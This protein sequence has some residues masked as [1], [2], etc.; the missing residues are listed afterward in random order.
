MASV[1]VPMG[2]GGGRGLAS[3]VTSRRSLAARRLARRLASGFTRIGAPAANGTDSVVAL[4]PGRDG[5]ILE[6]LVALEGRPIGCRRWGGGRCL[7]QHR[8]GGE[9]QA[10]PGG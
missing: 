8:A 3:V 9:P 2:L 7:G 5:L 1:R 6:R 4:F 10:D